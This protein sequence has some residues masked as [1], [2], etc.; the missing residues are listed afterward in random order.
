MSEGMK[1]KPAHYR[2]SRETWEIIV[3]EYRRGATV[4]ELS[5]RWRVSAHA[6][7]R[8]ITVHGATKRDWGDK[9]AREQA[10]AREQMQTERALAQAA[11]VEALFAD[12]E[13]E[14][15]P[16]ADV[17]MHN[18]LRASGRAMRAQ[19]WDEAKA[20]SQLAE[21]YGRLAQK[22]ER[23]AALGDF[24][25]DDLPLELIMMVA[26]DYEQ[27]ASSRL[28]IWDE[29]DPHPAKT[30]YWEMKSI[31]HAA[32]KKREH[33]LLRQLQQAHEKITALEQRSG[34]M[35]AGGLPEQT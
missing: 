33:D 35:Q 20:L 4:P 8:R 21:A 22:Q 6:L 5:E 7:R 15:D 18:A 26:L 14:G 11:R 17:L 34:H 12:V 29:K 32:R 27:C 9:M 19:M 25:L 31:E 16:S 13:G 24:T 10:G 28:A 30:K 1:E 2:L 3:D 23:I